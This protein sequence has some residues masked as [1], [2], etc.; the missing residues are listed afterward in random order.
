LN[1]ESLARKGVHGKN[2]MGAT[3]P[4]IVARFL[5]CNAYRFFIISELGESPR[6]D[7]AAIF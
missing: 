3:L 5:F 6:P 1:Q 7:R 4:F 2:M